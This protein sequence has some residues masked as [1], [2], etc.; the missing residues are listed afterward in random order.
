LVTVSALLKQEQKWIFKLYISDSRKQT[1]QTP[2]PFLLIT[3]AVAQRYKHFVFLP[4]DIV[5]MLHFLILSA[6]ETCL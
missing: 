5:M 6:M 2:Q 3:N 1:A 4:H